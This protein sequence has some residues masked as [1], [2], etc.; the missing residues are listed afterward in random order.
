M[1]FLEFMSP[2]QK[3]GLSY[4]IF[5]IY[6]LSPKMWTNICIFSEFFP[7]SKHVYIIYNL[8]NFFPSLK[9]WTIICNFKI[10]VLFYK[11]RGLSY[12][13]LKLIPRLQKRGLSFAISRISF[14]F[15]N[16]MDSR[17]QFL[18]FFTF[19]KNV[20]HDRQFLEFLSLLQKRVLSYANFKN[21]FPFSKYEDYHMRFLEFLSLLVKCGIL[22]A[23]YWILL[24][25]PK[26]WTIICHFRNFFPFS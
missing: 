26:M 1:Q 25:S 19:S 9:T 5:G 3:R 20:D 18:E 22:Y 24:S 11:K 12:K 7:F 15:S 16:N 17:M 23:I 13:Y 4:A 10:F 6:F 14:S 2:L 8:W 21:S